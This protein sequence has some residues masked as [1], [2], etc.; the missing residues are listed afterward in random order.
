MGR[1]HL[2]GWLKRVSKRHKKLPL[3]YLD[4]VGMADYAGRQINQLSGGPATKSFPCTALAQEAELY[5]MDEPFAG[6][7]AA[8]QTANF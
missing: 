2:I 5:F 3:H 6:V 7:D 4:M 1:Y 8:A